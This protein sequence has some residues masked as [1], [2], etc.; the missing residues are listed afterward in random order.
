MSI[1][2]IARLQSASGERPSLLGR[3]S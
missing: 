1:R 3:S 2:Q